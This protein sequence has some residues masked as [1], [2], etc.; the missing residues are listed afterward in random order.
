MLAMY[1]S[2]LCIAGLEAQVQDTSKD[3]YWF[4]EGRRL[5]DGR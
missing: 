2:E 3:L 1:N 5:R 4:W